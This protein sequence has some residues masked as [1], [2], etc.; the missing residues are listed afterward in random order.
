MVKVNFAL[1]PRRPSK[2]QSFLSVRQSTVHFFLLQGR[3]RDIPC[4]CFLSVPNLTAVTPF[5][6]LTIGRVALRPVRHPYCITPHVFCTQT[7]TGLLCAAAVGLINGNRC[8]ASAKQYLTFTP[9]RQ[10]VS[11]VFVVMIELTLLSRRGV[12]PRWSP[13]IARI[14]TVQAKSSFLRFRQA[15]HTVTTVVNLTFWRR[16]Y[17]F[18][19]STPCI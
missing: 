11:A 16:N 2:S 17:F 13:C 18:N 1:Y 15:V 9:Q 5:G 10:H 8:F 14:I 4:H 12:T 3:V 7:H 6:A 19:F